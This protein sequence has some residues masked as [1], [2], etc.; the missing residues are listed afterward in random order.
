MATHLSNHL[1][2][3]GL[4]DD[5]AGF[6][7]EA[8]DGRVGKIDRVNYEKTCMVVRTR[9]WP[10]LRRHLVPASAVASVDRER[11]VVY[12]RTNKRDILNGPAYDDVAGVDEEQEAD[13][14]GYYARCLD[15]P[16]TD[17]YARP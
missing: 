1:T 7:V 10:F 15:G 3:G 2:R 5:V 14:E 9:R 11:R 8:R 12:V 13:A 6:A 17:V 16:E 4:G